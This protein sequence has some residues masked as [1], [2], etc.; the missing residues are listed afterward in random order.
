LLIIFLL[1]VYAL[2][3][4]RKALL[5]RWDMRWKSR[6]ESEKAY[7]QLVVKSIRSEKPAA[8]LRNIMRWLDRINDARDPAQL[9]VFIS[10]YGDSRSKEVVDQLLHSV[11]V[12]EQLPDPEKLLN[13]LSSARRN[14]RQARKQRQ[15]DA[16][17]LPGLNPELASAKARS[18]SDAA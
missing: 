9:D 10:R 3:F 15:F 18:A 12:G 4:F 14:W 17:V 16:S 13:V 11:A 2:Y 1:L 7:F 6:R 5:K 8:A